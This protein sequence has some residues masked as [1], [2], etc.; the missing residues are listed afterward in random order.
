MIEVVGDG[1]ATTPRAELAAVL[2]YT[3]DAVVGATPSGV[4]TSWNPAAEVL[5]GY[6]VK[7]VLG[8]HTRD[9]VA[10]DRRVEDAE[11]LDRVVRGGRAEQYESAWMCRDASVAAVSLSA[12][13]V[14]DAAGA[15]LGVVLVS[16]RLEAPPG[17]PQRT[18][19]AIDRAQADADKEALDAQLQQAQRLEVLGRLAGGVAHDFNNLLAVILNY[20]AFVGEELASAPDW[21]RREAAHHDVGQIQRAAERAADLTHQLLAFARQEVVHARVLDLNERVSGVEELLRRTLGDDM[22]LVTSLSEGLWPIL[23]DPGQVEQI[24]VNLAINARD[25]MP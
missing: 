12:S 11:I 25:A 23:A 20:A 14:V 4:I 24:L 16:C 1:Q 5:Y 9:L 3:H 6:P 18:Q 21:D 13:A 15:V 19:E 7:E 8:R 17:A 2:A 22:E 10:E